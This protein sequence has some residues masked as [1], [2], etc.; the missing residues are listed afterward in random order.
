MEIKFNQ[1]FGIAV[2]ASTEAG[3]RVNFFSSEFQTAFLF[4]CVA[5]FRT[6]NAE[7]K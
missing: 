2:P 7:F 6:Q 3:F 4:N 5:Y 1:Y